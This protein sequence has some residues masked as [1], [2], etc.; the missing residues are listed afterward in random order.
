MFALVFI[1]A[2]KRVL[3]GVVRNC[4]FFCGGVNKCVCVWMWFSMFYF[5]LLSCN[6]HMTGCDSPWYC[7][8]WQHNFTK[9]NAKFALRTLVYTQSSEIIEFFFGSNG[10]QSCFVFNFF[11]FICLFI[12]IFLWLRIVTFIGLCFPSCLILVCI[13]V[14]NTHTHKNQQKLNMFVYVCVITF[15]SIK[16]HTKQSEWPKSKVNFKCMPFA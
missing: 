7:D 11:L 16:N 8:C 5:I 2:M 6:V 14:T 9:Y 4:C 1:I 12:T 3:D 15:I 10:Y 13:L